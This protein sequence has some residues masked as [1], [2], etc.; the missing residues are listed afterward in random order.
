VWMLIKSRARMLWSIQ[1]ILCAVPLLAVIG[2]YYNARGIPQQHG[3]VWEPHQPVRFAWSYLVFILMEFGLYA[4]LSAMEELDRNPRLKGCWWIAIGMLCLLPFYRVGT[5]N[6]LVM[7]ASIPSLFVLWIGVG[8]TLFRDV[9]FMEKSSMALL[10][11]LGSL[12]G[13][14][15]FSDGLIA[16]DRRSMYSLKGKDNFMLTPEGRNYFGDEGSYFFRHV[17]KR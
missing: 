12:V 3:W 13:F 16:L 9:P 6:D 8:K 2:L 10:V 11:S 15:H 7:R 1:N 17:A 4:A 5:Y 14:I